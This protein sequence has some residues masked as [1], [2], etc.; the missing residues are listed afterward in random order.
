MSDRADKVL[1]IHCEKVNTYVS[2]NHQF[3]F[4]VSAEV[5]IYYIIFAFMLS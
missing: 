2:Q 5:L 1:G 4:I 3:S